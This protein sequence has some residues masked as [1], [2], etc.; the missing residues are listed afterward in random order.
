MPFGTAPS[1]TVDADRVT[2]ANGTPASAP[3]AATHSLA[4]ASPLP[5]HGVFAAGRPPQTLVGA[6]AAGRGYRPQ[7]RLARAGPDGAAVSCLIAHDARTRSPAF[8]GRAQCRVHQGH[9]PTAARHAAHPT[10]LA[11]L[12]AKQASRNAPAELA[13][14]ACVNNEPDP[15]LHLPQRRC[16]QLTS[17]P[18][19][20]S[21]PPLPQP[22]K[23]VETVPKNAT[24]MLGAC[25]FYNTLT[26]W[27]RLQCMAIAFELLA[28]CRVRL[29]S[30]RC[31]GRFRLASCRGARFITGR[32]SRFVRP[33]AGF[34]SSRIAG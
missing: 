7:H 32:L 21:H 30:R 22:Y 2:Q 4:M 13:T 23:Q 16:P 9:D 33:P 10:R 18:M 19:M 29:S 5:A 1:A 12:R 8:Q 31:V 3:R 6:H 11:P 34:A 24:V 14:R 26:V 15:R 20:P 28:R 17:L 27:L 25:E